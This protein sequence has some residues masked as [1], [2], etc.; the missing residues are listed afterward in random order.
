[1]A[2][3]RNFAPALIN[4]ANIKALSTQTQ[5][6]ID[7]GT[8]KSNEVAK[9]DLEFYLVFSKIQDI[10]L[11]RYPGYTPTIQVYIP[12]KLPQITGSYLHIESYAKISTSEV[13]GGSS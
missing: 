7:D 1:M 5:L 2:F 10:S 13:R 6:T 4:S 8:A 9:K 3:K 12:G 11:G